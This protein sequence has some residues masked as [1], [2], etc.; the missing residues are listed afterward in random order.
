[1]EESVNISSEI[2]LSTDGKQQFLFDLGLNPEDT[3]LDK[4]E[5][6][7]RFLTYRRRMARMSAVQA[8]YLYDIRKKNNIS[9]GDNLF[10][11][12]DIAPQSVQLCEEVISFYQ[13]VFF[14]PEE[15]GDS[16]KNKKIDEPFMFELVNTAINN[17][18][19]ID[20]Y[21]KTHIN[22]NWT[23]DKLD[24][25]LRAIIRCAIAEILIGAKIEKAVLSSEYTNLASDYFNGKEIGFINGIVDRLYTSVL[26]RHPFVQ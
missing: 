11:S 3:T 25:I 1:M 16:K 15:Y 14:T 24:Y 9:Q 8:L 17:I 6:F 5:V 12:G 26:K 4:Q 18:D 13:N 22:S 20:G 19:E 7:D 2:K 10:E 23:I 21:I